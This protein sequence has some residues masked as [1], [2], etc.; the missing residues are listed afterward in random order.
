MPWGCLLC[1]G[2]SASLLMAGPIV[3]EV[4][5][6]AGPVCRVEA[7][8]AWTILEVSEAVALQTEVP[9][10]RLTLLHGTEVLAK[11]VPISS[12]LTASSALLSLTMVVHQVPKGFSA[13]ESTMWP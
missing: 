11:E 9:T 1:C 5:G 6:L 13:L 3:I 2:P 4:N 10:S 7:S 12:L 8:L